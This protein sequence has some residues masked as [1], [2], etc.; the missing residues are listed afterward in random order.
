MGEV[1]GLK[2]K[3]EAKREAVSGRLREIAGPGR[4]ERFGM[5][6]TQR[7]SQSQERMAEAGTQTDRAKTSE[8][9]SET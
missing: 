5:R 9:M 7:V 3:S 8:N 2:K 4:S 1:G 6:Q